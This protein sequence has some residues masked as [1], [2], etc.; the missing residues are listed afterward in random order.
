[1]WGTGIEPEVQ[2]YTGQMQE[3]TGLGNVENVEDT[4]DGVRWTM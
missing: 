3:P 1:M 4:V 2:D